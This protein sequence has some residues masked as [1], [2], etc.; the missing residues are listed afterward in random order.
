M[1]NK[2]RGDV[3]LFL[4][5]VE[6]LENKT[7]KPVLGIVPFIEKLGIDD[8]DSVSLDDKN[9]VPSSQFPVPITIAVVRLGKLSNFTDF[10]S[11]AGEADVN[12]FYATQPDEL[13]AADE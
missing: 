7:G 11:L 5:A 9:L 6:F 2:F 3:N 4:P 13:D 10:D 1:I 12:L 8:E